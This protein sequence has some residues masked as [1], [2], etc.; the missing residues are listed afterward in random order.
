[1]FHTKLVT[2]ANCDRLM[3]TLNLLRFWRKVVGAK[4]TRERHA[5]SYSPG[6]TTRV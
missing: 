4:G 2:V 6:T 1:M 5:T 3:R